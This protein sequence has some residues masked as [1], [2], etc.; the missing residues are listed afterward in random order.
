MSHKSNDSHTVPS[1]YQDVLHSRIVQNNVVRIEE[2]L[3]AMQRAPHGLEFGPWK[4]E[5]D[6]I[7]KSSFERINQMGE[8]S[9]RSIL[10]SIRETWV[11]Y[12]T[13]YGAVEVKS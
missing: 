10:E 7:W 12:I 13:H 1:Q 11:S 9:Q 2:H 8:S 4:R 3:E 5:V 6:E